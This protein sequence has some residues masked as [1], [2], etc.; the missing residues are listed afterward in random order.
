MSQLSLPFSR[1]A[2]F[3]LLAV[4][5]LLPA[6]SPV[7]AALDRIATGYADHRQFMGT[8]LVAKDGKVL[9]EKAYGKANVEWDVPNTTDGRFRL[10]SITKQFTATAILQLV[11]QDKLSL[12]AP[13]CKFLDGCPE[14]WKEINVHHLLNHTSG[15]PSYTGL[16]EFRLP[17]LRRLPLTPVEIAMLSKDKPLEFKPGEKMNYNNT[18]YVLLGHIIE[19]V[20]GHK[21]DEY[22]KSKI[23][24]PLS[25]NSSG[26]DQ[27]EQIIEKRVTGYTWTPNGYRNAAFLDMSLPHA[28]GSLYSTVG[29][30]YKWDRGLY[31]E[32][33]LPAAMKQKMFTP[34]LN[35]YA[36]GWSVTNKNNRQVISHGGGIPGFSTIIQRFPENDA[37]V[38]VLSNVENVNAGNIANSLASALFGEEVQLSW[39]RKSIPLSKEVLDRY[40]GRYKLP[41]VVLTV[42]QEEGRLMVQPT[43]QPKLQALA[44]SER[45]FFLKEVDAALEFTGNGSGPAAGIILRQGGRSMEG[46]RMVE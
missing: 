13:L 32:K 5:T 17:R 38:I 21:Y 39:D 45:K 37:V 9:L 44:E 16:P 46:Q 33:I 3:A 20:S 24:E 34:G 1:R 26:Y 22:I 12:D 31:G 6:Q 35:D 4:A 36:Y 18:G 23:F 19:K 42:T 29:D 40:A 43:D 25:M 10:G 11:A 7:A 27:T 30:L 14:A 8:V 15:I 28:A 2:L 41:P